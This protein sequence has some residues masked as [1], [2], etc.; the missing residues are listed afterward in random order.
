MFAGPLA[1]SL[2]YFRLSRLPPLPVDHRACPDEMS[3]RYLL[4]CDFGVL[5]GHFGISR[6]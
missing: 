1:L 6:Y 5:T 2:G 3:E 4:V